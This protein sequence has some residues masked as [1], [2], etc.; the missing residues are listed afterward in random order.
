MAGQQRSRLAGL[1]RER[2]K[3]EKIF[4]SAVLGTSSQNT[5]ILRSPRVVC[6]VTDIVA[7][8]YGAWFEARDAS[9]RRERRKS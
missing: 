1:G 4:T 6:S 2:E 3:R 8:G 9:H 7:G 5:S